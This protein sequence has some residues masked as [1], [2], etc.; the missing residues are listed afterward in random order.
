MEQ[1]TIDDKV[2]QELVGLPIENVYDIC[3]QTGDMN[4]QRICMNNDIWE[5]RLR[6]DYGIQNV[7]NA[8]DTYFSIIETQLLGV[9]LNN[10]FM[11]TLQKSG[12]NVED[13]NVSVLTLIANE[14]I[15]LQLS[16]FV[17]TDTTFYPLA[18]S[19]YPNTN[20]ML[21]L[22]FP[23]SVSM[24][25][26]RYCVII[27]DPRVYRSLEE[28]IIRLYKE[29]SRFLRIQPRELYTISPYKWEDISSANDPVDL[30]DTQDVKDTLDLISE[31]LFNV[32]NGLG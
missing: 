4:I 21:S 5:Y 17:Y 12:D 20:I 16:L 22:R 29:V 27:D 2:I 7:G 31:R 3:T 1:G 9:Y 8:M 24:E 11:R 30:I 25:Q 15:N 32:I 28:D 23:E 26:I 14:R 13:I 10:A 6:R 18:V 19:L